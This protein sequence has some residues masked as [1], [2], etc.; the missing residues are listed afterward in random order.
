MELE[1]RF[2]KPLLLEKDSFYVVGKNGAAVLR[3]SYEMGGGIDGYMH[4]MKLKDGTIRNGSINLPW[5][6]RDLARTKSSVAPEFLEKVDEFEFF[7]AHFSSQVARFMELVGMGEGEINQIKV[8]IDVRTL[9]I[10]ELMQKKINSGSSDTREISVLMEA[11]KK[12]KMIVSIYE[13]LDGH[14][15]H[16][17]DQEYWKNRRDPEDL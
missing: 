4:Y 17:W 6:P 9:E 5:Y 12:A 14:I 7:I 8:D 16:E 15:N 2:W 13:N 11:I 3:P 10:Y 1:E